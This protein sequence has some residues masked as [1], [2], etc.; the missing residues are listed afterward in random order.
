ML[1]GLHWREQRPLLSSLLRFLVLVFSLKKIKDGAI[2]GGVFDRVGDLLGS[3]I[4]Y[5]LVA[6]GRRTSQWVCR[7]FY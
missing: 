3:L 2:E 5:H 6:N 1:R 7:Y 4:S